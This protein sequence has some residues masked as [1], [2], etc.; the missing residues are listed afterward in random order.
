M[1]SEERM[2]ISKEVYAAIVAIV[3]DRLREAA[4]SMPIPFRTLPTSEP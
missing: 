1:S 3:D 2:G 4:V